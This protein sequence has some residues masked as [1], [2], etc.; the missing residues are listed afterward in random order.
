MAKNQ[1]ILNQRPINVC[2]NQLN[3]TFGVRVSQNTKNEKED[4]SFHKSKSLNPA[5]KFY[6]RQKFGESNFGLTSGGLY[7]S[8][9]DL[10]KIFSISKYNMLKYQG[11]LS[12]LGFVSKID[13]LNKDSSIMT[14]GQDSI[15]SNYTPQ[16]RKVKTKAKV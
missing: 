11:E 14:L 1:E 13:N 12:S 6:E 5:E 10:S 4:E 7:E 16:L 9:P 15:N 2:F 8:N 3:P